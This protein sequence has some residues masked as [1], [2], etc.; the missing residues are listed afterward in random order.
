MRAGNGVAAQPDSRHLVADPP[1]LYRRAEVRPQHLQ[2]ERTGSVAAAAPVR[3]TAPDPHASVRAL[4][5]AIGN[6]ALAGLIARQAS[7]DAPRAA[8]V[9]NPADPRLRDIFDLDPGP[10]QATTTKPR[11]PDWMPR[12]RQRLPIDLGAGTRRSPK[13]KWPDGPG[14]A[15]CRGACGP[16]CPDTCK[17]LGTYVEEYVVGGKGYLIE[18]P[19]ALLCGTHEGCRVHDACFDTAVANGE[20]Y[21]FGPRHNQCNQDAVFRFG[22]T[23]TKSW[24]GGGGPYDGWWVF[25]DEPQILKTWNVRP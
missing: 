2:R 5:S 8:P 1:A 20:R 13:L 4:G 21:L 3:R 16:D 7:S 6:R 22:P 10:T 9:L 23:K 11:S 18:F 15:G 14:E 17:P 12:V 24:M 25:V 19:D